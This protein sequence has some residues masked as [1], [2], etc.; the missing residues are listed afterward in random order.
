M[1][2]NVIHDRINKGMLKFP[3]RKDAMLIEEDPFPPIATV[4]TIDADLRTFLDLKKKLK[5]REENWDT[6]GQPSG[7]Y[8]Y[9]VKYSRP[10]SANTPV[11]S[12]TPSR[13]RNEPG[14]GKW[15]PRPKPPQYQNVH[16]NNWR[17][18]NRAW[19]N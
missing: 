19:N 13:W 15:I 10:P 2:K 4:N 11:K 16:G 17:Q 14:R 9:K 1:F 7:K 8:D 3:E 12:I 18:P 5:E 6:L